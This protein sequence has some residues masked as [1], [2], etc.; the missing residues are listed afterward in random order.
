VLLENTTFEKH[1][2]VGELASLWGLGRETVR[3]LVKDDPGL[4]KIRMGRKKAH[5][6]YS[7]PHFAA[8]RIH[9]RLLNPAN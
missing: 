8:Q 1:Y 6:F 9:T 4:I 2:R 5:T 7:V 3:R